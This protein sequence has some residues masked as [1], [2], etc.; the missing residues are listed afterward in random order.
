MPK[1]D[2]LATVEVGNVNNK[3]QLNIQEK[4]FYKMHIIRYKIHNTGKKSKGSWS[5]VIPPWAS[6]GGRG[7]HAPPDLDVCKILVFYGE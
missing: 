5:I 2:E 6:G 4:C 3:L 7:A 1:Q